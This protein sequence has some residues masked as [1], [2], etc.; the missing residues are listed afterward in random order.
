M[1]L[2]VEKAKAERLSRLELSDSAICRENPTF[3]LLKLVA[4]LSAI[5]G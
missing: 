5:L 1:R 3:L 4:C 2:A